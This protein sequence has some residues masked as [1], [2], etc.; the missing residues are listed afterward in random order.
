MVEDKRD[1]LDEI[2]SYVSMPAQK[3]ACSGRRY[4]KLSAVGS[5]ELDMW[6]EVIRKEPRNRGRNLRFA[7]VFLV[8]LIGFFIAFS[9]FS[10]FI[11]AVCGEP[12]P[13]SPP[14]PPPPPAKTIPPFYS[15]L[16]SVPL[17][18]PSAEAQSGSDQGT[19][20][21]PELSFTHSMQPV[22]SAAGVPSIL[23][24]LIGLAVVE[25]LRVKKKAIKVRV[26][27]RAAGI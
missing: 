27:S 16:P 5:N 14:Q 4:Q 9:A 6:T 2:V 21:Q 26:A 23:A 15:E 25:K 22:M 8:V 3:R 24:V 19:I 11:P 1:G 7:G 12:T 17:L 18:T 13:P 20:V 10:A